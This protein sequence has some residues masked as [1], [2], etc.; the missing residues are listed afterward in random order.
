MGPYP[1]LLHWYPAIL[2]ASTYGTTH[3][4]L[5]PNLSPLS[6]RWCVCKVPWKRSV[7]SLLDQGELMPSIRIRKSQTTVLLRP[8]KWGGTEKCTPSPIPNRLFRAHP[9]QDTPKHLL[10]P[11]F[12]PNMPRILSTYPV[13]MHREAH[14]IYMHIYNITIAIKDRI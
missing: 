8:S 13:H 3:S 9:R 14:R 11:V 1:L 4:K 12:L 5:N 7:H 6:V 2:L 10:L